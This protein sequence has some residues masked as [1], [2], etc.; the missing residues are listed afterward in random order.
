MYCGEFRFWLQSFTQ[1][2]LLHCGEY[3]HERG[4]GLK[5]RVMVA[6]YLGRHTWYVSV[7]SLPPFIRINA[8]DFQTTHLASWKKCSFEC[9]GAGLTIRRTGKLRSSRASKHQLDSSCEHLA[10]ITSSALRL[11]HPRVTF[12]SN[13]SNNFLKYIKYL[14]IFQ[15]PRHVSQKPFK[16]IGRPYQRKTPVVSYLSG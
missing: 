5:A 7:S 6:S 4:L 14:G 2:K 12:H 10:S 11:T 13:N 15:S 3:Q 16:L 1:D 9:L 8:I